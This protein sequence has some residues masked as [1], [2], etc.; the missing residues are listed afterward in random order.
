MKK[1]TLLIIFVSVSC[2]AQTE[3]NL[4]LHYKF[5]GNVLDETDNQFD[6]VQ[7]GVT[8]VEDRFGNE[9]SAVYFNGIDSFID[10]PNLPALKPQLPV[11][12][13]FWIKYDNGNY[14]DKAVFNTSFEEDRSS[15]I[16]FNSQISTGNYAINFGDGSYFY[17]PDARRSYTSNYTITENE[18][19][20]VTVVVNAAMDMKIYLRCKEFGGTYSG[21]GGNLFYSLGAGSLGRNDRNLNVPPNFFKGTLDDFKYWDRALSEDEIFEMCGNLETSKFSKNKFIIY[22]NPAQNTLY[23]HSGEQ[24]YFDLKIFDN[25]GR[26]VLSTNNTDEI[27]VSNFPNGLYFLTISSKKN[28][29]TEKL[30]INR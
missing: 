20:Q 26:L 1:I 11:S 24:T 6:G 5:D 25:L 30:I 9:N 3:E 23:V 8:F 28:I 4:L 16:Y 2:F 29:Q 18:W 14:E 22:P 10:L 15:G 21:S 27:N 17:R 12:F 13:S 19:H 7:S